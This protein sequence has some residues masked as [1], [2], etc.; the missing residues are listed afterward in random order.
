[1]KY[2]LQ[3]ALLLASLS[4]ALLSSSQQ[5]GMPSAVAPA[6]TSVLSADETTKLMPP[7]VFF[8]GQSAPIQARNAAAVRFPSKALLLAA[9][10]DTSGYS[11][12]IQERYQAYLITGQAI[13]IGGHS[14][15]AGAYGVG[16]LPADSFVVMDL[17]GQDLFLTHSI[18]DPAM[19]RPRP[20][21]ILPDSGSPNQYRLY[22]GR[23]FVS[24]HPEQH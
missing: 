13:S 3:A 9:L 10:V 20:L 11:S 21:Q 19:R 24:F 2:R 14:L 15:P 6:T 5:P 7:V 8:K 1:M 16:F 12:Q 17:G 18:P 23:S 22:E 4:G